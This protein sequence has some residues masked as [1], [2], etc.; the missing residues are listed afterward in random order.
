MRKEIVEFANETNKPTN[1]TFTYN[2]VEFHSLSEI[3]TIKGSISHKSETRTKD[4]VI[5]W[6]W[7]YENGKNPQEVSENDMIDTQEA[8]NLLEYTF[9]IIVTGTQSV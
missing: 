8:N 6:N 3:G 1:L 5:F 9:D 2:G 4:I 7:K